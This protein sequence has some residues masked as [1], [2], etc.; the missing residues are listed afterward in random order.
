MNLCVRNFFK[1][2]IIGGLFR[3]SSAPEPEQFEAVIV[4]DEEIA[5]KEAEIDK[6]RNKSKLSS[7]H[8]NLING[9]RPYETPTCLA[10][11]TVKYNRKLYGK[12]GTASGVNPSE[13]SIILKNV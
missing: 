8:F 7:A 11:K 12:Y 13:Y 3:Y 5:R 6:K 2:N 1:P 10:H 9:R 4:D